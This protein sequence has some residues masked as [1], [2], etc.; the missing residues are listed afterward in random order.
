MRGEGQPQGSQKRHQ[1]AA[2]EVQAA[3]KIQAAAG[4]RPMVPVVER[5]VMGR[6]QW[7]GLGQVP[8]GQAPHRQ[9]HH[10]QVHRRQVPWRQVH[11]GPLHRPFR[12]RMG[13]LC[14]AELCAFAHTANKRASCS[15]STCRITIN[16]KI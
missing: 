5:A 16:L 3:A 12:L 1:A 2:A 6:A 10:M 4:A 8:H 14:R 11:R 15:E 13:I 9:I 7:E